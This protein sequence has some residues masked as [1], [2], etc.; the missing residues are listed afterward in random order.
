MIVKLICGDYSISVNTKHFTKQ[1][2]YD[3]IIKLHANCVFDITIQNG[4]ILSRFV[5]YLYATDLKLANSMYCIRPINFF[6]LNITNIN[7]YYTLT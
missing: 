1:F 6:D 2:I 4:D 3:T 5:D 7:S